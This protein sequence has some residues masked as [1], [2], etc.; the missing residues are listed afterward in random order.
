MQEPLS[1]F[2][3][4]VG[5]SYG[6]FAHRRPRLTELQLVS[7]FIENCQL[8]LRHSGHEGPINPPRA[9]E[10]L[11]SYYGCTVPALF[12]EGSVTKNYYTEAAL[13]HF[14]NIYILLS[15]HSYESYDLKLIR[16][17]VSLCLGLAYGEG[18][19]L[20]KDEISALPQLLLAESIGTVLHKRIS[21][22]CV[23]NVMEKLGE[24]PLNRQ[25]LL[26]ILSREAENGSDFAALKLGDHLRSSS[27]TSAC[28][29]SYFYVLGSRRGNRWCEARLRPPSLA[30]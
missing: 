15:E 12:D 4:C 13:G 18:K 8:L 14:H 6:F 5:R 24:G 7:L 17:T 3:Y 26:G 10:N 11:I 22:K 9:N 30:T 25:K 19:V 2:R 29:A 28:Q 27:P 16:S 23:N 21:R 20:P 1:V